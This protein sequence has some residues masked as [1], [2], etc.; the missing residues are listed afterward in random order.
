MALNDGRTDGPQSV[1]L[2]VEDLDDTRTLYA[3]NLSE[4]G[5]AVEA[6]SDGLEAVELAESRGPDAI[7][8]DLQMPK[9]DG[10]EAIRLIRATS[11]IQPY[12][13]VVSAYDGPESRRA[14]Y[15]SGAD[16]LVG[17]PL[18]PNVLVTIIRAAVSSRRPTMREVPTPPPRSE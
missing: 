16:D 17:K 12:I 9:M 14:A 3:E 6:A 1:V 5:F 2:V 11:T 18:D 4:A 7:V 8:M 13:L 10:Y 15:E